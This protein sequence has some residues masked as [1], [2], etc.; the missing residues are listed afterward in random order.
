MTA[1]LSEPAALDDRAAPTA[2][3]LPGRAFWWQ[4]VVV[5]AL[6]GYAAVSVIPLVTMILNSFRSHL[7][8]ATEPWPW[9]VDPTL[10]NYVNAW[11]KASFSTYTINSLVVTIA[12]V[13]LS[14]VVALPAAYAIARWRFRGREFVEALFISG[15]FIPFMLAILPMFHLMDALRLIDNPLSLVLV[16]AANGIPFSIFVFAAF[17]R[18]LPAELEEA[19]MIDGAGP[20]RSFLSVSVPLVRPAIATVVVF[21]F[22]PIWND[23]LTPLVLLRS[24]EKFTLGVGLSKFFGEYQTDWASLF[25]GLV[26]ATVPLLVLFIVATRQIIT[27]ITAGIGK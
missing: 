16:Y 27:G 21:R 8:I 17:F 24:P 20:V 18:H 19:A 4:A 5:L 26:I 1:V 14:T 23:F 6:C 9:P 2:R 15:L 22:V 13:A 10:Q 11:T 3:R 25:A 12:S 7:A